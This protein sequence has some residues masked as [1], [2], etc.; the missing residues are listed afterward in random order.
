MKQVTYRA[1]LAKKFDD[2]TYVPVEGLKGEDGKPADVIKDDVVAIDSTYSSSKIES[3]LTD[4][5][6]KIK[7]LQLFKFPNMTIIGEPTINNGQISNFSSTSYLKFPFIVD[8]HNQAFEINMEFTTGTNVTNQE[9]IF[10][11]DFGLAFAVRNARFVIA[12]SSNGTNWD[13][14]EGVGTYNVQ[15]NTTYYVKLSWDKSQ[16]VLSYSLN[17]NAFTNDIIKAS[18]QAPYPKQIYVGVGEN[19]ATVVNHFSGIINLNNANLKIAN[20]VV[21]QGMD[22]A[23]LSTRADISL[24]NIDAD[25]EAKIR[26]IAETTKLDVQ[27]NGT[28]IV[29]NNVANIPI[30][31]YNTDIGLFYFR[32]DFGFSRGG[33]KGDVIYQTKATSKNLIERTNNYNPLVS[34]NYDEAVRLAMCDGKGAEWSEAEKL[35]AQKRIYGDF[36]LLQNVVLAEDSQF[37]LVNIDKQEI[38]INVHVPSGIDR[39][40]T[41]TFLTVQQN[42]ISKGYAGVT[43]NA[44]GDSFVSF[45]VVRKNGLVFCWSKYAQA[46]SISAGYFNMCTPAKDENKPFTGM[47][48]SQVFKAGT[49]ITI[50]AR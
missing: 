10:D 37:E 45:G 28:S 48:F 36:E 9:N 18:T 35:E 17:N 43:F 13:L 8:F 20:E 39:P 50:Y 29:N 15:P 1:V 40:T 11:S 5:D 26:D 7:E 22:D 30:I 16:Y 25:G 32:P 19:F 6:D 46:Y 3:N 44:S 12:V 41:T 27:V 34:S 33:A 42:Y 47:R 21:W 4:L 49:K 2:G 38:I 31:D 14:G 24:S 23:G